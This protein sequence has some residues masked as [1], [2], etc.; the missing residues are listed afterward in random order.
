MQ[1]LLYNDLYKFTMQQIFF[2][3][4]S[5]SIAKYRFKCRNENESKETRNLYKCKDEVDKRLINLCNLRFT[6]KEINY[7]R[8]LSFFCSEYL[9]YLETFQLDKQYLHISNDLGRLEIWAEGPILQVM[10]WEIYLLQIVHEVYSLHNN[11]HYDYSVERK[12]GMERLNEKMRLIVDYTENNEFKFVDFG[13]RRAFTRKWHRTV[14]K[15]LS[16]IFPSEIFTGTSN[17][18]LAMD[19]NLTPVG[20]FAHEFVCYYQAFRH[21]LD[22]QRKALDIWRNFYGS[23][24]SIALSDTL[25]V[26][27]FL[28]DSKPYFL[29]VYDGVR[30]DSGNP[31]TFA[32]KIIKSYKS[33][34]VNPLGK[35]IVFSDGLTIPKAIEIADYCK[36]KIKCSFGIGTNLTN[37][38]GIIPLQNVYKLVEV[39]GRPVAKISDSPG[40]CMCEND[41]YL[42]YLKKLLQ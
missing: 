40:K 11:K 15:N 8:N 12:T 20:T 42:Q 30:H 37:D 19:F 27:K 41:S 1:S 25:G 31:I 21:P 5:D 34:K 35:T 28:K 3:Q 24:L 13:T 18:K 14:I 10:M 36:G 38:V 26:D 22:S 7:L 4:D 33:L 16:G 6:K 29:R 9:N 39:N 2:Y 17:V 32:K 23:Q